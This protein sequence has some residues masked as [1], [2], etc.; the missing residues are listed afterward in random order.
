M[1]HEREN[2]YD[3]HVKPKFFEFSVKRFQVD[4][5][6]LVVISEVLFRELILE[7]YGSA[8]RNF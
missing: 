6:S 3:F 2:M 1:V 8:V 4:N 5:R 7:R